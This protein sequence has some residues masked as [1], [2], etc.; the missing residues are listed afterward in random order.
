MGDPLSDQDQ[1]IL[2][3]CRR[4]ERAG[5]PVTPHAIALLIATRGKPIG[6][7]AESVERS[8]KRLRARGFVRPSACEKPGEFENDD[9]EDHEREPTEAEKRDIEARIAAVRRAK[10]IAGEQPCRPGWEPPLV[11]GPQKP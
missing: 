7:V 4:L 8:L 9:D 5:M 3:H 2:S 11:R 10:Q 1:R 6:L